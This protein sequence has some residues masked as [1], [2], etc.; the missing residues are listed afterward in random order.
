[1]KSTQLFAPVLAIW[2]ALAACSG[3]ATEQPVHESQPAA[4]PTE[5]TAEQE[6]A[7]SAEEEQ[8]APAAEQEQADPAAGGIV[9]MA[10]REQTIKRH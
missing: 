10:H 8:A 4:Q 3:P 1:M 7:T 5:A 6:Q 9:R 2:L